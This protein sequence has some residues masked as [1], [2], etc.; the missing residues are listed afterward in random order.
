MK[1]KLL[2]ILALIMCLVLSACGSD[3]TAGTDTTVSVAGEQVTDE[4]EAGGETDV[5]SE[6]NR[7]IIA[8]ALKADEESRGIRFI[9]NALETVGAG[10]IKNAEAGMEGED[11][12]LDITAEDDTLYRVYLTGSGSVDAVQNVTTGEWPIRSER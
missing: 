8:D 5:M 1:Y 2:I 10:E 6:N 12:Y 3:S 11:R 7:K 4:N 9:L